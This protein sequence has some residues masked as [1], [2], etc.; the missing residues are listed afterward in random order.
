MA[1]QMITEREK[2]ELQRTFRSLD[3]DGNGTLSRE[4]L[5]EAFRSALTEKDR[6]V[7]NL[8]DR[9]LKIIDDVDINKSG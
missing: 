8:D 5:M 6:M 1:S 9:I 4:E 2:D 7:E 3:K